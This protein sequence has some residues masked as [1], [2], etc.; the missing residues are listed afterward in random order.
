MGRTPLHWA[1]CL[2]DGK[3]IVDALVQCGANPRHRDKVLIYSILI[4]QQT[5]DVFRKIY[6]RMISTY[7]T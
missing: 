7:K 1:V 5:N 4:R 6:T 2:K 3:D